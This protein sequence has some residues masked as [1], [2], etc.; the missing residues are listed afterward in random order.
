MSDVEKDALDRA[1]QLRDEIEAHRVRLAALSQNL[2]PDE[3]AK[4]IV[5]EVCD[6]IMPLL[7]DFATACV[8]NMSDEREFLMDE[9]VP[10]LDEL[11]GD[12]EGDE[13]G[14]DESQLT[15]ADA[16]EYTALLSHYRAVLQAQHDAIESESVKEEL[17]A[18][19]KR[20]DAAT[21][22]TLA[23]TITDEKEEEPEEP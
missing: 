21:A 18:W 17:A 7:S 8:E 16:A 10:T 14:S 12:D 11:A 13:G 6:T 3:A 19:I 23:I 15:V 9:I 5:S 22:R 2:S 4:A 1:I 20:T